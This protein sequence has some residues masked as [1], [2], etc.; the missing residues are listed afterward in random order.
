MLLTLI[1]LMQRMKIAAREHKR[2]EDLF[3]QHR[4]TIAVIDMYGKGRL[5]VLN[6]ML[7]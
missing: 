6:T 5:D 7:I 1:E 2:I 4:L 3:C